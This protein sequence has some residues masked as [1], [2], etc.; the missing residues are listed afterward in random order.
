MVGDVVDPA[1][2][3]IDVASQLVEERQIAC[4]ADVLGEQA[5][6]Q[7]RRVDRSVVGGLRH[8]VEV[9]LLVD[10]QL[11][12]DFAW[13]L[14]APFVV[15][16]A[17]VLSHQ[18]QRVGGHARVVGERLQRGDETVASE[19]AD[20]PGHPRSEECLT[21]FARCEHAQI[22][23]RARKHLVEELVVALDGDG[24]ER[25]LAPARRHGLRLQRAWPLVFERERDPHRRPFA[26]FEG[27]LVGSDPARPPRAR[28]RRKT[29]ES[30][31]RPLVGTV[32]AKAKPAPRPG[33][34][35]EPA[36]LAD[37]RSADHEHVVEA[38][39]ELEVEPAADRLRAKV[40]Y[41]D[42]L[43]HLPPERA[44]APDAQALLRQHRPVRQLEVRIGQLADRAVVP[45]RAREQHGQRLAVDPKRG[46]L[47]KA[48]VVEV[49]AVAPV[50][51]DVEIAVAGTQAED[52]ARLRGQGV[53]EIGE[54]GRAPMLEQT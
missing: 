3:P 46:T 34:A 24:R 14:V 18:K 31:A 28:R 43:D 8:F 5:D 11:V 44:L 29:D 40:T 23:E 20:E 36:A 41:L 39:G 2:R 15:A 10:P 21:A 26:C 22:L 50:H 4:P 12:Q 32:I 53:V 27:E 16:A 42:R 35:M 54:Q 13:L 7:R 49:E 37:G 47:E 25:C 48:R 38:R 1:Q 52:T 30:R 6:E 33:R 51:A 9:G 45:D 17:L 19:Q